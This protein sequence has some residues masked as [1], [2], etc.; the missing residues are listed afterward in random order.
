VGTTISPY[1]QAHPTGSLRSFRTIRLS[2]RGWRFINLLELKEHKHRGMILALSWKIANL[3]VEPSLQVWIQAWI[4]AFVNLHCSILYCRIHMTS[5]SRKLVGGRQLHCTYLSSS[6]YCT[7]YIYKH[8]I[9]NLCT[10]P[11][12]LLGR[13]FLSRNWPLWKFYPLKFPATLVLKT[14]MA[15]RSPFYFRTV[16]GQKNHVQGVLLIGSGVVWE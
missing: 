4:Q 9:S 8:R 3:V 2:F 12:A 13:L 16:G 5:A 15:R 7:I 11:S 1:H 6:T 10:W 14:M